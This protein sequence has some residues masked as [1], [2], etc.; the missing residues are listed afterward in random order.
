VIAIDT[1]EVAVEDI[2][3]AAVLG[4]RIAVVSSA[5]ARAFPCAANTVVSEG[6]TVGVAPHVIVAVIGALGTP[7]APIGWKD[8]VCVPATVDVVTTERVCRFV[9]GVHEYPDDGIAPNSAGAVVV[10]DAD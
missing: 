1:P 10:E 6:E 5:A 8:T 3:T 9:I 2:A 7:E 4:R